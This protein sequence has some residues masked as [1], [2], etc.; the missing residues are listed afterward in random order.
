MEARHGDAMDVDL[1]RAVVTKA[2]SAVPKERLTWDKASDSEIDAV[3]SFHFLPPP[4]RDLGRSVGA[5]R[6]PKPRFLAFG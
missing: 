1:A 5:V 6:H 3:N 4:R 2:S